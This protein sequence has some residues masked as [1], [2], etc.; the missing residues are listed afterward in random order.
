MVSRTMPV[1]LAVG[2]GVGTLLVVLAV[3]LR[4]PQVLRLG[5]LGRVAEVS[6]PGSSPI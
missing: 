4:W 6:H 5:P 3:M 1:A 2:G